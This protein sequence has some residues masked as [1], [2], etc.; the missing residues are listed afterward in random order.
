MD[1]ASIIIHDTSR[2]EN[3]LKEIPLNTIKNSSLCGLDIQNKD[4]IIND[5]K[6]LYILRTDNEVYYCGIGS[7]DQ[8][9]PMNVLARNFY[10]IFKMV[11]LPYI[12]KNGGPRKSLKITAPR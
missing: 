7:Q 1:T 11:F 4:D 9:S 8:N 3:K 2:L 5:Q 10:N 6:C 12:N